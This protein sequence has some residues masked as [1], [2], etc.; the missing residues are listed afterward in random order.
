MRSQA[1]VP[2]P[3]P[4]SAA[5]GGSQRTKVRDTSVALVPI[6]AYDRRRRGVR[7]GGA[8]PGVDERIGR[9][10][11]VPQRHLRPEREPAGSEEHTSEL[12]SLMRIS[13]A[14]FCLKKQK[15]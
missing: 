3:G 6:A 4:S 14:V 7:G 9:Q 13:Y 12:Q 8:T 5:S 2:S 1:T 15:T 11:P 10:I